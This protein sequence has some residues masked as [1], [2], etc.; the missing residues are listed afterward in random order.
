MDTLIE[1]YVSEVGRNLPRKQ[2]TDIEAEIRSALEDTLEERSKAMGRQPDEEMVLAVLKE[3]GAP[4]KVAASYQGEHY[5]IGP[6]LYPL[7]ILVL[8]VVLIVITVIALIG[9]GVRASQISFTFDALVQVLIKSVA[10]YGSSVLQVLGNIVLIF[11]ILQ[12]AVPDLKAKTLEK[13]WD[14]LSL[15]NI[16]EA[17]RVLPFSMIWEIAFTIG[18]I[19]IFNFYSGLI[20]IY[21]Y[22]NG[23]WSHLLLLTPE[24]FKFLPLLNLI[25]V[26]QIAQDLILL[27]QG[28]WKMGT[29]IFTI[30]ISLLSILTASLILA[31]GPIAQLAAEMQA[32]PGMLP[33]TY[34]ILSTM[35]SQGIRWLMV[36]IIVLSGYNITKVV[37]KLFHGGLKPVNL[38]K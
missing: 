16:Q 8:R 9:F 14:P 29:R 25:W 22:N 35:L 13:A 17:D 4:E 31:D 37:L 24:F 2:R 32:V 26:F 20:G 12:W 36:I 34:K 11:A 33:E 19:L 18:A 30:V 6:R 27:R 28:V 21:F 15:K 7:F 1:R 10:D 23:Q 5:L 38:S 3:Y